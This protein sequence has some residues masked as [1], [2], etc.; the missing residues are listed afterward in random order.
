MALL[1]LPTNG[2]SQPVVEIGEYAGCSNTQILIPV[3]ITDF[4]EAGAIT[5]YIG[6][7]TDNVEYVDIE[8]I[9]VFSTGYF[10]GGIS[11]ESQVI[12]L[13][14][15]GLTPACLESGI[16]YNNRMLFKN[17]TV[18][19]N[20]LDNCEID[21]SNLAII[22]DGGELNGNAPLH[23][24]PSSFN[25]DL[26]CVF[27]LNLSSAE[28]GLID[29]NGVVNNYYKLGDVVSGKRLLLQTDNV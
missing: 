25:E 5:I 6:V 20:F 17:E 19:F 4:E 29:V 11:T 14:W 9:D 23:I 16:M 10:D 1:V 18:E 3:E 15:F 22:V 28:L 12:T 26:N 21:R 13:N 24:Y 8:N 2:I 7:D 27:S